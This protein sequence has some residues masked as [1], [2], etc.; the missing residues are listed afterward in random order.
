MAT[1][2]EAFFVNIVHRK[3]ENL[4]GKSW[5]CISS[6]HREVNRN[7]VCP[8]KIKERGICICAE[9]YLWKRFPTEDFMN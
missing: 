9:K 7:Y 4:S 2:R 5:E 6:V 1:F 8:E 3:T